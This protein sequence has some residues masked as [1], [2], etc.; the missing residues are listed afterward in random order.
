MVT[1]QAGGVLKAWLINR[2]EKELVAEATLGWLEE[3]GQGRYA[4]ICLPG[5]IA[6]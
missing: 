5:G 4:G 6:A 2:G 1:Y 3:H